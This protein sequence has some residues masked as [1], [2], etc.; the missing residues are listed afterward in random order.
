MTVAS[1]IV[2]EVGRLLPDDFVMESVNSCGYSLSIILCLNA[3]NIPVEILLSLTY[4]LGSTDETMNGSPFHVM[5][6]VRLEVQISISMSTFSEHF[7]G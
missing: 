3:F 5:W 6:V 4:D 1:Y 2:S 7:R